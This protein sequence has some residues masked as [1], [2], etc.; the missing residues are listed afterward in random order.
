MPHNQQ[1]AEGRTTPETRAGSVGSK[2]IGGNKIGRDGRQGMGAAISPMLIAPASVTKGPYALRISRRDS[3]RS[4]KCCIP[5]STRPGM[6]NSTLTP[7]ACLTMLL[8]N[9]FT[10]TSN[11]QTTGRIIWR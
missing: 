11:R 1:R 9:G 3:T 6:Q 8:P 4:I 10:V 5:S 2:K 7:R